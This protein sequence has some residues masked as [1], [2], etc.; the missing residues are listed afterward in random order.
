[1]S[2]IVGANDLMGHGLCGEW[3]RTLMVRWRRDLHPISVLP[4]LFV[5]DE[6]FGSVLTLRAWNYV[7]A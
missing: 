7:D 6:R 4:G 2:I 1:M 5:C 3:Q